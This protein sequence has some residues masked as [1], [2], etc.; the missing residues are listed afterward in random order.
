MKR[1]WRC[2]NKVYTQSCR[3]LLFF[4]L[5]TE[6]DALADLFAVVFQFSSRNNFVLSFLQVVLFS[7]VTNRLWVDRSNR[8][9]RLARARIYVLWWFGFTGKE[10]LFRIKIFLGNHFEQILNCNFF[11]FFIRFQILILTLLIAIQYAAISE[12]VKFTK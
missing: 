5:W 1:S 9:I 6:H 2:R 4:M 12:V 10:F 11:I 3:G 7:L 8:L